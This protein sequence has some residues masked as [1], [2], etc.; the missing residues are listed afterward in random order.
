M[1]NCSNCKWHLLRELKMRLDCFSHTTH[2]DYLWAPNAS[3]LSWPLCHHDGNGQSDLFSLFAH[4]P[5]IVQEEHMQE[6]SA[7]LMWLPAWEFGPYPGELEAGGPLVSLTPL[8]GSKPWKGDL[9]EI[10]EEGGHLYGHIKILYEENFHPDPVQTQGM[11]D[12][13]ALVK[14]TLPFLSWDLHHLWQ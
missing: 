14:S 7:L 1:S 6:L 11:E 12:A 10:D 4:M 5:Y 13:L 3:I 8:L 9:G 2:M